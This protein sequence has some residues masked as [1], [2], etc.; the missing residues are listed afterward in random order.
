[1]LKK[2]AELTDQ[3]IDAFYFVYN[4]LG[5]GFLEKIYR[6]ALAYE[7]KKRGFQ[8]PVEVPIK[9]LYAGVVMGEYMA[10]FQVDRRCKSIF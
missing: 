3:I 10:E 4:T 2:H 7:L 6:N 8:V 5:W 1:M 9:V